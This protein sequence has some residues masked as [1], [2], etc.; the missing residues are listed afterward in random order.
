MGQP[1]INVLYLNDVS[2]G[3]AS[4]AEHAAHV[5]RIVSDDLG[6]TYPFRLSLSVDEV[7]LTGGRSGIEESKELE[8]A[9]QTQWPLARMFDMFAEA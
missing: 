9:V 5:W 3:S 4:F 6:I 7:E 1:K 8:L 2:C